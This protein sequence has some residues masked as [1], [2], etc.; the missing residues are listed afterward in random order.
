MGA[1]SSSDADLTFGFNVDKLTAGYYLTTTG[2][3]GLGRQRVPGPSVGDLGE[4]GHGD[5]D[6]TGR[7]RADVDLHRSACGR[8][9]RTYTAGMPLRMRLQVTG[10]SP[11]TVRAKVWPAWGADQPDW[12]VSGDRLHRRPAGTGRD[13]LDELPVEQRHQRPCGGQDQRPG[14]PDRGSPQNQPPT[15]RFT[16]WCRNWGAARRDDVLGPRGSGG[17]AW[18]LGDGATASTASPS[19]TFA[20]SGAYDVKLTVTDASGLSDTVTH[21]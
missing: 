15:A 17:N 7:G 12:L 11:T 5:A 16:S 1:V 14:R 3:A 4:Q 18:V 9:G 21:R 20:A 13:R 8:L 6:Q 19:H 10:T 2:R